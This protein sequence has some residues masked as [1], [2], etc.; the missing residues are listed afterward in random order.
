MTGEDGLAENKIVNPADVLAM[1]DREYPMDRFDKFFTISYIVLNTDTGQLRYSSA[2][3]PMPVLIRSRGGVELLDKGGTVI[4]MGDMVPFEE[5][6]KKMRRGDRLI[7]YTDGVVEY[8]NRA[9]DFYGEER[10]YLE[11][12]KH[13]KEPL[14]TYCKQIMDSL[15]AYGGGCRMQ[16]DIT[17]LALERY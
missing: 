8:A 9:G 5:G 6:E 17:L 1:L 4:G 10:L 12:L 16:D 15:I 13:R 14:N 11:L 2:A 7:I 3:H